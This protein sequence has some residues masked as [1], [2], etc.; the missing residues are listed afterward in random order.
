[1]FPDLTLQPYYTVFFIRALSFSTSIPAL[2]LSMR[3]TGVQRKQMR[4]S[5]VS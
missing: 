4:T 3:S 2:D 5:A 1:M